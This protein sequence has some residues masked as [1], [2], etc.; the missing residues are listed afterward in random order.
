MCFEFVILAVEVGWKGGCMAVIRDFKVAM[1]GS[2]QLKTTPENGPI[3]QICHRVCYRFAE[4][5]ITCTFELRAEGFSLI[6]YNAYAQAVRDGVAYL[7]QI[8]AIATNKKQI[9]KS[10]LPY[11]HLASVINSTSKNKLQLLGASLYPN[12]D[13]YTSWVKENK[14]RGVV[15]VL[16]PQLDTPVKALITWSELDQKGEPVGE[17]GACIDLAKQR[18]I[19]VFNLNSPQVETVLSEIKDFLRWH[20]IV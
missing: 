7:S 10:R 4:L 11:K 17:M 18:G 1:V 14:Y 2:D 12:W 6:A 15:Q 9:E 19:P 13:Q 5:G 8:E 16:G 3:I 20:E